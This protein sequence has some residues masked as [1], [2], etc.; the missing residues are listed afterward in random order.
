LPR[1]NW[2]EITFNEKTVALA[3][4]AK[5]PVYDLTVVDR[6]KT[7]HIRVAR[8]AKLE[9]GAKVAE[10]EFKEVDGKGWPASGL[11]T[12]M[13]Q[14][15]D[16]GLFGDEAKTLADL[17]KQELFLT[18]GVTLFYRLP[19]EEYDRLLPLKMRPKAE[20]L[21]RVGLVQHPHCEPDLA[22]RVAGLVNDL[23]NEDFDAR[24]RAQSKLDELGRAAFVHLVRMRKEVKALEAKR[25][26]D[27]ILDKYDVERAIKR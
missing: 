18:P 20:K 21:V 6:R 14:L 9:A 26:L 10:L 13:G 8:I 27:E 3:S 2:A 24:E 22:E 7:D 5:H 25:R 16:A 19:Q 4:R 12:L 11:E 23:S 15:K 1:G 17:W